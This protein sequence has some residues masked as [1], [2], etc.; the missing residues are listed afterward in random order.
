VRIKR[1]EFLK[2]SALMVAGTAV[3]VSGVAVVALGEEWTSKRKT[4]NRHQG[5]TLLKMA[6]QMFPH[7]Q[8][9]DIHYVKVV[10]E[11][12]SEANGSAEVAKLLRDG[13]KKIDDA[14]GSGFASAAPERQITAMTSIQA[15][16]FFQK[17]RS[18][19]IVS[20]Y[21]NPDVWRRFGYQGPSFRFGGYIHRG[22]NNLKWLPEPPE[23]A[24]PKMA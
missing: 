11:L 13:V 12:D 15:T 6:R 1:R 20:L 2:S 14:A 17:V 7:D 8:L 22:F 24:S 21:N 23:S 9:D 4:L 19:E 3:A 10:I 18:T 5:E 16:E